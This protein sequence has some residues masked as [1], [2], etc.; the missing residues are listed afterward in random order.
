MN[1]LFVTFYFPPE[2][3]APQRRIWEFA[4]RLKEKGHRVSVLTGFPN[5]PRGKII[6]PYR[7]R[8]HLREDMNGIEVLRVF[9]AIGGRRGKWGRA[10]SEGSFA[11]ASGLAALLEPAFDAA[12]VESPSLLSCWTGVLLKRMRGTAFVMHVSD[13]IPD[14][15]AGVGMLSAGW[16]FS[17]LDRMATYFY[18]EADG[19][20]AVTKGFRERILSKG[21]SEG[22]V[23]LIPNGVE[24]FQVNHPTSPIRNGKFRVVYSG[25]LGRAYHLRSVLEAARLLPTDEF[26]FE[27]IG[28]GIDRRAIERDAQTLPQIKFWGGLPVNEM[29]ERLYEAEAMIIP[30]I[31]SEAF[32][33]VIPSRMNDAMAAGLPIVLAARKGEAVDI[34]NEVG[35]GLVIE[36]ENAETLAKALLFLQQNREEAA[37]MG[38]RGKEFVRKTR[39]RSILVERLEK[40]L[41][42]VVEE[43]RREK[44]N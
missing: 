12:V 7:R 25:S 43:K 4:V 29:F 1:V 22:K 39:V 19:I 20:V 14:L 16:I 33:P 35:A 27:I 24:D 23:R 18:R 11:L 5:Y 21:I 40:L 8:P 30:L 36:P 13:L 15:A 37:K 32:E 9:H 28:D 41:L 44:S 17:T 3:G 2:I 42:E 38:E 34:V 6:S 31:G 10:V 26:E